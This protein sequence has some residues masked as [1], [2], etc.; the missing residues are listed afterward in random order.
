[1][2][3]FAEADAAHSEAPHVGARAPAELAAV[4][5]SH[6]ELGATLSFYFK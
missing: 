2:G 3:H 5:S 1:M 6:A 4:P